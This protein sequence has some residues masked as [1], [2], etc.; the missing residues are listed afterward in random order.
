[1]VKLPAVDR[2][3]N[4]HRGPRHTGALCGGKPCAGYSL[5]LAKRQMIHPR[6][7][8]WGDDE[9]LPE[10]ACAIAG[11]KGRTVVAAVLITRTI[12]AVAPTH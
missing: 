6:G 10:E 5:P 9:A 4:H 3:Y 11:E 2:I 1:M 12:G 8:I 7:T